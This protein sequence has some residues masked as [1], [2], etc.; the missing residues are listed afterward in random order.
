[1]ASVRRIKFPSL[2]QTIEK[3]GHFDSVDKDSKRRK[4]IYLLESIANSWIR[5]E[6]K[7]LR[8]PKIRDSYRGKLFTIGS[9]RLGVHSRF[10]DIDVILVIPSWIASNNIRNVDVYD[11]FSEQL[12]RNS[13][14]Q[15]AQ[16]VNCYDKRSIR[17]EIGD[18]KFDIIIAETI[19]DNVSNKFKI[20][21]KNDHSFWEN[22]KDINCINEVVNARFAL[23]MVYSKPV[24]RTALKAIRLWARKR[25]FYSKPL[26]YLNGVGLAI[27]TCRI[28][29][30]FP[31]ESAERIVY[32]FFRIY[33]QWDWLK[34]VKIRSDTKFWRKSDQ[35]TVVTACIPSE[36]VLSH[37]TNSGRTLISEAIIGGFGIMKKI[38]R[39]FSPWSYL[40]KTENFPVYPRYIAITVYFL[41]TMDVNIERPIFEKAGIQALCPF[42]LVAGIGSLGL[43]AKA[44]TSGV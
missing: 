9:Y 37:V 40:F 41:S 24:Y 12:M 20:P 1:M 39:S 22:E 10:D 26:G 13:Q 42:G 44:V 6:A 25:G 38:M 36:N 18:T 3:M 21:E 14:T 27:M 23:D 34:P 35:M 33:S 16:V 31:M 4:N 2:Q 8:Y 19:E 17:T 30:L 5:S 43:S 29:Q 28:C 15:Y 11:R 7:R 32:H